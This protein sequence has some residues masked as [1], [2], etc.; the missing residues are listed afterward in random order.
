MML[1]YTLKIAASQS[2]FEKILKNFCKKGLFSEWNVVIATVFHLAAIKICAC[3]GKMP[4]SVINRDAAIA[5]VKSGAFEYRLGYQIALFLAC[6][7]ACASAVGC[8]GNSCRGR[9]F[10]MQLLAL[11]PHFIYFGTGRSIKIAVFK[12]FHYCRIFELRSLYHYKA[13]ER[14]KFRAVGR[15]IIVVV[16]RGDTIYLLSS[17]AE[18]VIGVI[19]YFVIALCPATVVEDFHCEN[20]LYIAVFVKILFRP[21][22]VT[23]TCKEALGTGLRDRLV[24]VFIIADIVRRAG[25]FLLFAQVCVAI[26]YLVCV[27]AGQYVIVLIFCIEADMDERGVTVRTVASLVKNVIFIACYGHKAVVRKVGMVD[28]DVMIRKCDD[29]ISR[30]FIKFFYLFDCEL[31]VGK[32]AVAMHIRLEEGALRGEEKIFHMY[33]PRISPSSP[34]SPGRTVFCLFLFSVSSDSVNKVMYSCDGVKQLAYG[35][36]LVYGV[37]EISDV[38]AEADLR[39]PRAID[40]FLCSVI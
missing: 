2:F 20:A 16:V 10:Y 9:R 37:Y 26:R 21:G 38:F 28:E 15:E 34:K 3:P 14:I 27:I 22:R 32:G 1:Y 7:N 40:D 24:Y 31:A 39:I 8:E 12:R 4:L 19:V 13:A 17:A 36:I 11:R 6:A 23:E 5:I 18:L 25:I 30:V 35:L 33:I 29:R